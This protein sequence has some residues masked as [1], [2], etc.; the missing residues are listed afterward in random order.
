MDPSKQLYERV[1]DSGIQHSESFVGG[2]YVS[3]QDR[4]NSDSDYSSR[5]FSQLSSDGWRSFGSIRLLDVPVGTHFKYRLIDKNLFRSGGFKV[6]NYDNSNDYIL[7][8]AFN[9]CI[10][11]LQLSDVKEFYI[12]DENSCA[13]YFNRPGVR[14]AHSVSLR[15]SSGE[16]EVVYYARRPA[17]ANKFSQ[18]KKFLRAQRTGL[19]SF[20][21]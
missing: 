6:N 16:M 9:G 7:Y 8:K 4:V 14:T 20:R 13:V 18:T 21:D 11:P 15:N 10:F 19:W 12:K 5:Y 1:P 3:I 2:G 17:D